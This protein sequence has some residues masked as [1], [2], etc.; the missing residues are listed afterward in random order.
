MNY[1]AIINGNIIT[2]QRS[3][4][5]MKNKRINYIQNILMPCLIFSVMTGILTGI[6]IFLFKFASGFAVSLSG[7]IYGFVR[8]NAI[9]LPILLMGVALLGLVST[10]SVKHLGNC[11]GGGIPT[12]IALLR[13]LIE[14]RWLRN[15]VTVFVSALLSF[16]GGI[17]LGTEGPSV[18]MG[19]AVGRGTVRLFANKHA[20]WDRYI[21]T[22][23]ACTGFAAAT[24]APLTGIFFAFEEAHRRFSPMIFMSAA[25]AV[26]SGSATMNILC[27]LTNTDSAF[28][29]F[30][31][32]SAL[33]IKYLW[34]ALVVGLVCG[35]CA[36]AFTKLYRI[37]GNFIRE[38]LSRLPIYVKIPT[39]FVLTA[40]IGYFLSEALGSGHSLV[41]MM[42]EGQGIW[43]MSLI[44]LAV[45]AI[46]LITANNVG[47]TG[48]LF[49]PTLAFGAIVGSL[50][51]NG[52]IT[53]GLLPEEY[54]ITMV[55]IGI[56][57]FLSASSRTPISAVIFAVEALSGLSNILPIAL[58]VALSYF[59]IEVIGVTA[60][61]D[62]VVESKVESE[63]KGKMPQLID[64][65]FTVTSD[66][67]VVGKEIRDI[68]WPPTCVVTSVRKN[69][70]SV[71]HG[72]LIGEGDI[73]HLHY[74]AYDPEDTFKKLEALIGDQPDDAKAEAHTVNQSH[75]VPE[76]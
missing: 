2:K 50:C 31:I 49:V 48:G 36:V 52:M 40:T 17:P 9:Y 15:I 63:H 34:S 5:S 73:L 76:I 21:M 35:F 42:I 27:D 26:I 13:G 72:S 64:A 54:Y 68:L 1:N 16:L 20:A 24:G 8:E 60:F 57:S 41:D 38:R 25:S 3:M 67:F 51:G 22:G 47:I 28:F 66:A 39:V 4:I 11:K 32:N 59:I 65:H 30:T 44:C 70:A 19:T 58:G 56:A 29:H 43:Y 55:V 61:T 14:F 75:Q 18:Q 10:L 53:L 71:S 12:A 69:P 37:I 6:I 23:G 74:R 45:R 33:P 62:T 7:D 46:L